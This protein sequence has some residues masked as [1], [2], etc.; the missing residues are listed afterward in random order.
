[1]H[2]SPLFGAISPRVE[3]GRTPNLNPRKLPLQPRPPTTPEMERSAPFRRLWASCRCCCFYHH[4]SSLP[5]AR[6]ELVFSFS[7]CHRH[8]PPYATTEIECFALILAVVHFIGCPY[9]QPPQPL[10]VRGTPYTSDTRSSSASAP[11]TSSLFCNA[12]G[13]MMSYA[14]RS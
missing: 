1:M 8:Q 11:A 7:G 2:C 6:I 3:K 14:T 5:T 12:F 13:R 4:L 10:T 9:Q